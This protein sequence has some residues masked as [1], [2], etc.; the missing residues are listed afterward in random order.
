MRR[1]RS[2]VILTVVALAAC[3]CGGSAPSTASFVTRLD[4]LCN[5]GNAAY[6]AA[7]T[8]QAQTGVVAH[9]LDLFHSLTPPAHLR[10]LYSRYLSVLGQ[11]LDAL[12]QGHSG[13]VAHL[14]QT[15]A[16]PLASQLGARA[17]ANPR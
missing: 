7:S 5:R 10:S 8:S 9:Y 14:A 15:A 4:T 2:I 17:C 6:S 11:E 3:A 16:R 12:R 1:T 13:S